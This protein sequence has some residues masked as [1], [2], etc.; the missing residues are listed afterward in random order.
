MK[1]GVMLLNTSRGALVDSA[2]LIAALKSGQIGA[3]GLDVFEEEE[4][5]FFEDLSS[6]IIQDDVFMRPTTFPN[7][8]IT[9]HQAFFTAE[10]LRNIAVTTLGNI[11]AFETGSGQ[12]YRV[13]VT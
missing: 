6:H 8:L 4:A 3:L 11:T 9:A 13:E 7:V 2:A 10:A 5:L 12:L 1:R